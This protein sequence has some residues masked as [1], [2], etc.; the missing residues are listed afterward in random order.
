MTIEEKGKP[1]SDADRQMLNA[2]VEQAGEL[3]GSG[4]N[5]SQSV[6][7]AFADLYGVEREL[8][9]R[10]SA[11]FGGGIGRMRETCGAACGLFML[12]GLENGSTEAGDRK[13]KGNN[14]KLVQELAAEFRRR[15]GSCVCR[16]L[17]GITT[18][19][20]LSPLLPKHERKTTIKNV[21]VRKSSAKRQPSTA[22]TFAGYR[23]E[24]TTET[25]TQT[26]AEKGIGTRTD[27]RT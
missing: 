6:V 22:T 17:L 26:G 2:R 18:G 24:V 12:A 10:M 16:E 19:A 5:C 15:N 4:Y 13:G 20:P 11:P 27:N 7:A 8:A 21:P 25:K 23:S 1:V 3:F 9:L 14:Y